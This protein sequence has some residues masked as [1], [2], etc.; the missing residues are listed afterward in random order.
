MNPFEY[1]DARDRLYLDGG[2]VV[3]AFT[4]DGWR[5]GLRWINRLYAEGLIDQEGFTQDQNQMKQGVEG[6]TILY[7]AIAAGVPAAFS[8]NEGEATRNFY[9]LPPV[10][11][12]SGLAPHAVLSARARLP[13]RA[14]RDYPRGRA[15]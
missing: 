15:S 14:F 8:L 3:A 2:T 1:N 6:E 4:T 12:P 5:D 7:G 9:L 13:Q 11:G 10:A